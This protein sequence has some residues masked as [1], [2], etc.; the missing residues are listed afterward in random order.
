[1]HVSR[2][3]KKALRADYV[4][5]RWSEAFLPFHVFFSLTITS[6]FDDGKSQ[7]HTN[8]DEGL[9]RRSI[10][11]FSVCWLRI[12]QLAAQSHSPP[13]LRLSP[14]PLHPKNARLW[15]HPAVR[16]RPLR[17]QWLVR[18]CTPREPQQRPLCCVRYQDFLQQG[19]RAACT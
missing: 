7:D 12:R 11:P 17:G 8:F 14:G 18:R 4:L 3:V 13:I 15:S 1:M 19:G 16:S 9:F 6:S 10:S 5:L 2:I